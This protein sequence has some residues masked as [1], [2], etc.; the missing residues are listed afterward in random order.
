MRGGQ[1]NAALEAALRNLQTVDDSPAHLRRQPTLPGDGQHIALHRDLKVLRLDAG[2]RGDDPKLP[3]GFEDVERRLPVGHLRGRAGPEEFAIE[4][5]GPFEHRAGFRPHPTP[6]IAC[7]HGRCL[8]S[9]SFRA[10][11][12]LLTTGGSY[13]A[14]THRI[15]SAWRADPG[16]HGPTWRVAGWKSFNQ[17]F[18]DFVFRG[19]LVL[20]IKRTA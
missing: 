10:L 3:L 6:R 18:V 4:P 1:T 11:P 8:P 14:A 7:G 17:T 9:Q 15:R 13:P 16:K 2:K 20:T 19:S 5:I 12:T